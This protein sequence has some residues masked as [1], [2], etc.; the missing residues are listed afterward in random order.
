MKCETSMKVNQINHNLACEGFARGERRKRPETYLP[1]NMY[2]YKFISSVLPS[3]RHS[4]GVHPP[5]IC[6]FGIPA[7]RMSFSVTSSSFLLSC[8]F[9]PVTAGG[10]TLS[11]R[12]R[13]ARGA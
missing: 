13:C 5:C 2:R 9:N 10:A 12:C 3:N 7:K 11:V 8:I 6:H 4:S 1:K